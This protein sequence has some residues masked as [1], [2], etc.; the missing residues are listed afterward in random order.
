MIN[1]ELMTSRTP[2]ADHHWYP[3]RSGWLRKLRK[4][5]EGFS[6]MWS[7]SL[8]GSGNSGKGRK[9]PE[10][11]R[12]LRRI[13]PNVIQVVEASERLVLTTSLF[14]HRCSDIHC[15]TVLFSAW[16]RSSS[17]P[18]SLC[19]LTRA[20]RREHVYSKC[21]VCAWRQRSSTV[22]GKT[23]F[24]EYY[25]KKC[26]GPLLIRVHVRQDK[27]RDKNKNGAWGHKRRK[28]TFKI[29]PRQ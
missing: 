5:Q 14:Y 12:R 18:A 6:P 4:A 3:N 22:K 9:N 23:C 25:C 8:D 17:P 11:S 28:S 29:E 15:I 7:D 1:W 27:D 19:K 26:S 24:K 10:N 2:V 16:L 20:M 13:C 21:I